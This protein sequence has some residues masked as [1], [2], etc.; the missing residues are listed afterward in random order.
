MQHRFLIREKRQGSWNF[1]YSSRA[2]QMPQSS[3]F[4]IPSTSWLYNLS[5]FDVL[6]LAIER[7]MILYYGKTGAVTILLYVHLCATLSRILS[8][9][10]QICRLNYSFF[11]KKMFKVGYASRRCF[12]LQR[13][14]GVQWLKNVTFSLSN[15]YAE[16]SIDGF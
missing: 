12:Q 7:G 13:I 3:L 1:V 9:I 10:S 16:V 14:L 6:E 5:F 2:C 15:E 11:N 8:A 4:I